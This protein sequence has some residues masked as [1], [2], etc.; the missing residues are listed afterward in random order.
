MLKRGMYKY[1]A[2]LIKD[3]TNEEY[4]FKCNLID[5]IG[6]IQNIDLLQGFTSASG[7]LIVET[8]SSHPFVVD[9]VIEVF[10]IGDGIIRSIELKG[11]D[12]FGAFLNNKPG[13]IK[14]VMTIE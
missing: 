6:M 1:G 8:N 4:L 13:N 10:N 2:K 11:E 9:D 14:R 5:G 12:D 3:G 7:K